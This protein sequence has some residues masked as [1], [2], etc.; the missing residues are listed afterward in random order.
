MSIINKFI[1]KIVGSRNDRLIKKLY[2][3][4]EQINDLESSLQ[5]LSDEEL[6][7]KTN[8]FKDRLNKQETLDALL[9]EA[10]A[11]TREASKRVIGLRHHDVQLIG[12]MVLNA[13]NI[14]EMGT[15][16][17]K[18]LVATLTAYL[19][20]LNGKGVHV[21]TVNDYL[22]ARDAQWMGKVFNFLGLSVGV[23]VSSMPPEEKQ[24]AYACDVVYATNN[25]LGF[26]YLRDN[27]AFTTE[28]KVQRELNFAIIDE[29]DSILIDEART[30]L[31]I[32][33]PADDYSAVYQAINKMIPNFTKQ[34]ESGEG[35]E[36]VVEVAGD[37]T[38][39]EKHKQVF[40]TDD[41]H[42]KA[43]QLLIKAGALTEGASLYDASNILLMQHLN[44]ALRAHILFHKD[45]H[46]IVQDDE[47]VIVDEFTGRTMPGR[48]WSEGLHQAIEAKEGVS[49]KKENQTLAS[50]T[51]QNYFRLYSTLSGMTGTADTEAVEFQD[52]YGL[53]CVIVPPNKP[54]ARNDK[55]DQIYLTTEEKFEAIANDVANCQKTGQPVLVGTSTIENSELISSLLNKNKI[56]HEVLNAKQHEREATIIAN[57]G[58]IRSVTIATNMAGRGTDI[59]L[60]GKLQE[61]ADD[62]QK[63]E[64]QKQHELVIKAGGLHIVGTERNESRRVDNQLR[65]R[66]GRQGDVGSTRFYLSLEDNL[67][68]I[69][70]SEKM[71][72]MMQRLGM[73]KGEAIEHKMVNRAIEN[74]QKKV[75]GMNYDARKH[76]LEYDDVANDQR[77]VIYQ[78][79]DELMSVDDVRDR[80]IAIRESVIG[81]LFV[82]YISAD[83]AEEDWDVEGLNNALKSDYSAEFPLQQWLDD[84][85]DVDELE[86][87]IIHG[88]S[89]ICDHKED[90]VGSEP[91]RGFEKAVMLQTL[92]HYWKDHLASMDYLRQSVN[93]RGYAQKNPTQEYKRESFA[94]FE[95]LLDTINIEIVKS[96]SSVAIN[97]DTNANDVKQQN[98]EDAQA[99]HSGAGEQIQNEQVDTTATDGAEV[100]PVQQQTYTREQEKVGRNDPCPCGSGKKYKQCHGK[101]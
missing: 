72:A 65:G 75:E 64:W 44:S 87:R 23:V 4:V 90:M 73:E 27:M 3:T 81:D 83:Q 36:V 86:D 22:A 71:A 94:M 17:G 49:I 20:A 53:E 14:A 55:S 93:L 34:T 46:Y 95:S 98:N 97:E 82:G 11:V 33:G 89:A 13:G 42:A 67:M 10:F 2:K 28:Q 31:I 24:A 52:I 12:G 40:L 30:P 70:A 45:D 39:D 57:A 92:D 84:G 61:D 50:I 38:V 80:F 79:R 78:L 91:M 25:E 15:G 43:E 85:V 9:I 60:G 32:S 1:A 26:D 5:A 51:F 7:A 88:L 6:S 16:E 56:K 74:A 96:L 68:R 69:F 100:D 58:A 54:S 21:I 8:F 66:S 63:Q 62:T 41:G 77:K 47:V 99:T 59:V 76:L 35:K 19:N 29:V 37:Y 18:T 48:R 101:A